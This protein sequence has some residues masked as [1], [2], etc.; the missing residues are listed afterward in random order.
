MKKWGGQLD[1]RPLQSKN[2]GGGRVPPPSPPELTPLLLDIT[3]FLAE[4]G[5]P[6]RGVTEKSL[7]VIHTMV[8]SLAFVSFLHA[9]I[10]F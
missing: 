9:M 4:R 2:W 1:I 5:L 10:K 3:L 8:C 6:F 7:I